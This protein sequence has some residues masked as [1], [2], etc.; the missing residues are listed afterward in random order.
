MLTGFS[1][2]LLAIVEN[3]PG[4][5]HSGPEPANENQSRGV[6]LPGRSRSGTMLGFSKRPDGSA[7]RLSLCHILFI[8]FFYFSLHVIEKNNPGER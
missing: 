4:S 6:P 1:S 3:P 7:L 2:E 5:C 8:F